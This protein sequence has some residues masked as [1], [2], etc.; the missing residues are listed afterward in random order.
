MKTINAGIFREYD[1]RGIVDVDL[2]EEVY[3][4]IGKAFGTYV[5]GH[6]A[7]VVSLGRD[8]S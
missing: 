1:I 2:D 5:K 8:C 6:G 4:T 3:E 7:K